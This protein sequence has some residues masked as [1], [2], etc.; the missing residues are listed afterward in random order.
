MFFLLFISVTIVEIYLFINLFSL[1][2]FWYTFGIILLTGFIG[3]KLMKAQGRS[4]MGKIQ[5][6]LAQGQLPTQ[7]MVEGLL[8]IAAGIFLIT[9]GILTDG[10]GFLLLFP[11]VRKIAG[12][13][14]VRHFKNKMQ[15]IEVNPFGGMPHQDG[16]IDVETEE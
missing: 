5:G 11:P 6:S 7:D 3:V 9:P 8:V 12:R 13:G 10:T 1:I 16:V 14:L 15:I 4:I 2:G